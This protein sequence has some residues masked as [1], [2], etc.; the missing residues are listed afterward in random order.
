MHLVN[1]ECS[2]LPL[3]SADTATLEKD[4][5]QGKQGRIDQAMEETNHA[6]HHLQHMLTTCNVVSASIR[7]T[8]K[9]NDEKLE[10]YIRQAEDRREVEEDMRKVEE[11]RLEVE[12]RRRVIEEGYRRVREAVIKRKILVLRHTAEEEK[13]RACSRRTDVATAGGLGAKLWREDVDVVDGQD[14]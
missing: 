14:S 13:A 7:A 6:Q 2:L 1:D 4:V 12:M 5:V 11:D 8:L 9:S 3:L 10:E